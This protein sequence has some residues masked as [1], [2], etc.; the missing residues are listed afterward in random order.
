[1]GIFKRR[2]PSDQDTVTADDLALE[3]EVETAFA[4]RAAGRGRGEIHWGAP[5][6]CPECGVYG[7]VE[8]VDRATGATS[9][10]CLAS[11][12]GAHWVLTRRGLREMKRRLAAGAGPVS[13]QASVRPDGMV[14]IPEASP[15]AASNGPKAGFAAPPETRD[16]LDRFEERLPPPPRIDPEARAPEA[17]APEDPADDDA[18]DFTIRR[19]VSDIA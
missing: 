11:T 4:V 18:G 17:R 2:A 14:P 8:E 3:A 15:L 7:F 5:S 13:A 12:C 6:R 19:R 10:R 1:M 9:N 16:P